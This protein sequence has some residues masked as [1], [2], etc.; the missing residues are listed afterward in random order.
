MK[1][2]SWSRLGEPPGAAVG[3]QEAILE[4]SWAVLGSLGVLV[5]PLGALLDPS[6]EFHGPSWAL[7]GPS[8]LTGE[9]SGRPRGGSGEGG[10][11]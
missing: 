9:A 6:W 10:G 7:L 4:R 5:G 11:T 8:C 3:R 2:T 1:I